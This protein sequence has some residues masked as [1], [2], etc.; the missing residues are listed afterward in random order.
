LLSASGQ[1]NPQRA[2]RQCLCKDARRQTTGG[3]H[4]FVGLRYVSYHDGLI[5][6]DP[7]VTRV[8]DGPSG[9]Q[10]GFS[11]H[12]RAIASRFAARYF[13][14]ESSW[15]RVENPERLASAIRSPSIGLTAGPEP[16][17]G[18]LNYALISISY[19][20]VAAARLRFQDENQAGTGQG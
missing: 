16:H 7:L 3:R 18:R 19:T 11:S 20:R 10:R 15:P 5:S 4:A 1:H 9:L 13:R 14:N 6:A 17:G 12:A 8:E 2:T